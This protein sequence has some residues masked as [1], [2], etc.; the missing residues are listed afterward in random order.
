MH[1]DSYNNA[2]DD[3]TQVFKPIVLL[4][5]VVFVFSYI[6]L[7]I[8][9][10]M[11]VFLQDVHDAIGTKDGVARIVLIDP[12]RTMTLCLV[13]SLAV[14]IGLCGWLNEG[15]S[16]RESVVR[17]LLVITI[18]LIPMLGVGVAWLRKWQVLQ[19]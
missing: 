4:W 8:T 18:L 16:M 3:R 19:F 2:N 5:I 9:I 1:A 17:T 13:E 11:N 14:V 7:V 10:G 6:S 12:F 15:R